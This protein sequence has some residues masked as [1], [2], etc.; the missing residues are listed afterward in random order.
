VDAKMLHP[1]VLKR[2]LESQP[3]YSEDNRDWRYWNASLF[4]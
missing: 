2:P 1:S 4:L 3:A